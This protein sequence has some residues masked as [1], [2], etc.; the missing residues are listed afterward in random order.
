MKTEKI[1]TEEL[2]NIIHHLNCRLKLQALSYWIGRPFFKDPSFIYAGYEKVIN[3]EVANSL[4]WIQ[5]K[6]ERICIRHGII[7]HY[8]QKNLM[9]YEAEMRT[10]ISGAAACVG[11]KK[12]YIR[13]VIPFCQKSKSIKERRILQKEITPLCK[14]LKPFILNYWECLLEILK[15]NFGF[16]DYIEYC[17]QKKGIDY[18][19]FY[20]K[21]KELLEA[22]ERIYF[23][24]IEEWVKKRYRLPLNEL[25][26][27]DAINLLSLTEFD[28][29]FPEEG[30]RYF[31]KF[32][33]SVWNIDVR[34]T[35]GLYLEIDFDKKKSSQAISFIVQIPEEVY[36][37][38]NPVGGWIDLET[39]AH[40][41]GHGL[42]AVHTD[43]ELP[44]IYRDL[45]TCYILSEVFA[46]LFQDISMS[47]P[48]LRNVLSLPEKTL[49]S[50][51]FH[52]VLKE[53]AVF[54]RY[55][56][57]FL[58]EFE[59]FSKND[60]SDGRLYS[61]YMTKYTGFYYQPEAH[62]FDLVPEF[63]S[64]DYVIAWIAEAAMERYMRERFGEE[65]MFEEEAVS[66]VK[67][68]WSLGN[69]YDVFRFL[70]KAGIGRFSDKDILE[71]WE[72]VLWKR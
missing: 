31:F 43:P 6:K 38:M 70:E 29:T 5:D 35:E 44:L 72:A 26:R 49:E 8:L 69:K 3:E 9:P 57:K 68:W 59:M 42:S 41:L 33:K 15:K 13:E 21:V 52:K 2:E 55:C 18:R 28:E 66:L 10:W 54:R 16:K 61:E 4:E 17:K 39:I 71:R 50:I 19:M 47:R 27:F 25:T 40:E 32:L 37:V 60:V 14:F 36:V 45:S 7:D 22:T 64:L 11:E 20:F 56:A 24:L 34:N 62:L 30:I 58:V 53:I 63:Y 1:K 46:F 48:F 23:P 65:W 67:K 51:Y 12:V